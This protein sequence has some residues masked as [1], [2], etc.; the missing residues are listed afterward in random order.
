MS[1]RFTARDRIRSDTTKKNKTPKTGENQSVDCSEQDNSC[2]SSL[3]PLLTLLFF[4]WRM[5]R[6]HKENKIF[7]VLLDPSG[8]HFFILL[9]YEIQSKRSEVTAGRRKNDDLRIGGTRGEKQ[10]EVR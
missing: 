9:F 4:H 8:H 5:T 6:R 1:D 2:D 3:D 7:R 10:E